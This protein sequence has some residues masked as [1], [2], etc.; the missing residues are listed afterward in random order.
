MLPTCHT[1]T[2]L[3][4]ILL[5]VLKN[6]G[7]DWNEKFSGCDVVEFLTTSDRNPSL[8]KRHFAQQC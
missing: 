1:H 8:N 7:G 4:N 2:L 5:L 3:V 6:W